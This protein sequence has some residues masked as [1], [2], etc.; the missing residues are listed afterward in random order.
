MS[1]LLKG[2]SQADA[3]P[4]AGFEPS[5]HYFND[6]GEEEP[7]HWKVTG[8]GYQNKDGV[9]EPDDANSDANADDDLMI[10][11]QESYC[12]GTRTPRKSPLG[13]A[14]KSPGKY[15]SS[16]SNYKIPKKQNQ[17]IANNSTNDNCTKERSTSPVFPEIMSFRRGNGP[18]RKV[19]SAFTPHSRCTQEKRFRG[20]ATGYHMRG[21]R[22][23]PGGVIQSTR[24]LKTSGT[25]LP[26][27][28]LT[29][30]V[31]YCDS[32]EAKRK[33]EEMKRKCTPCPSATSTSSDRKTNGRLWKFAKPPE[34]STARKNHTKQV[35]LVVEIPDDDDE[36]DG[37]D[38]SPVKSDTSKK[39]TDG[40]PN[41]A[42]S[43]EDLSRSEANCPQKSDTT[44]TSENVIKTVKEITGKTEH[45]DISG[46]SEDF[47]KEESEEEMESFAVCVHCGNASLTVGKCDY[48]ACGK[49]I[50][51]DRIRQRKKKKQAV[52]PTLG[53]TPG[54]LTGLTLKTGNFYAKSL[55]DHESS[56]YHDQDEPPTFPVRP[57]RQVKTY[58]GK[59]S[60]LQLNQ[61]SMT[62][63]SQ[64]P[65][66][67][68]RIKR[69]AKLAAEPECVT[70]SS[71]EEEGEES[72]TVNKSQADSDISD[73][74]QDIA[75]TT[76]SNN[77]DS[78]SEQ[79][80][81]SDNFIQ[82][83]EISSSTSSSFVQR[84]KKMRD[85]AGRTPPP[86]D[87]STP[88][89]RRRRSPV[90]SHNNSFSGSKEHLSAI[91]DM[92]GIRIGTLKI[93]MI[94][95]PVVFT[96]DFID[97]SIT[98]DDN[99]MEIRLPTNDIVKVELFEGRPAS[100]VNLFTTP[101]LG[102]VLRE[103]LRM[104]KATGWFDPGSMVEAEKRII[105]IAKVDPMD[106]CAAKM[107]DRIFT[108]VGKVNE[109]SDIM[110][111]LSATKANEILVDNSN[112]NP[113]KDSSPHNFRI[114]QPRRTSVRR[115]T[116]PVVTETV[117]LDEP[118][119]VFTGP[120]VKL[121]SYPPP[122]CTGAITITNEDLF[123]LHE[124]EFLNDVII[125]FYLK[126]LINNVLGQEDKKRTHI[127]SSFF[128]KRLSQRPQRVQQEDSQKTLEHRRHKQVKNWTRHVDLFEKD[129]IVVPINE[130][131]H[132][133][134][135][136]ICFP[137]LAVGSPEQEGSKAK[138]KKELQKEEEDKNGVSENHGNS[139]AAS[140]NNDDEQSRPA[141]KQ[142]DNDDD[143]AVLC[144]K[145]DNN[146]DRH[147]DT[148]DDKSSSGRTDDHDDDDDSKLSDD[149]VTER[150]E[151]DYKLELTSS[152]DEENLPSRDTIQKGELSSKKQ[153]KLQ[154]DADEVTEDNSTKD[155]DETSDKGEETKDGDK[156]SEEPKCAE[157]CNDNSDDSVENIKEE[158]S[159]SVKFKQP[160]ILLFDSL[161]GPIH[162]NV[163]KTLK[164]YLAVEWES[165]KGKEKKFMKE[166][167]RGSSVKVPQQ[168]NYSD[169]GVF[170]LHYVEMFFKK[171]PECF[172][173]PIQT[174]K[175]WFQE[176]EIAKK[177]E[178]IMDLINRLKEE[179]DAAKKAT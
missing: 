169:C 115:V 101:R 47:H 10:V 128:Y 88:V 87:V 107:L 145:A 154:S 20:N 76:T 147:S 168:S 117:E 33:L 75:E 122:P 142:T 161:L 93:E 177:R 99:Q 54:T 108:H 103:R 22:S 123:C 17:S 90:R 50:N 43:R 51:A 158:A 38:D 98:V 1:D 67:I 3:D 9:D 24:N 155:S 62:V 11:E 16:L 114:V 18:K 178:H 61:R 131:A 112:A 81:A 111:K 60:I 28:Y 119:R 86:I 106:Q 113:R 69:K 174:L 40:K 162:N 31:G 34:S 172:S 134:L 91:V 85:E 5:Y 72:S 129:F 71:D 104:K 57:V 89:E 63:T 49:P 41:T 153:E 173:L 8:E 27:K 4:G 92:R 14:H 144:D 139:D 159:G 175:S 164:D 83:S 7:G 151:E 30:N 77:C 68:I 97:M 39:V 152:S 148:P 42:A 73:A 133:F 137:G 74:Q 6:D 59:R 105:F 157:K 100:L 19:R 12:I 150:V 109:I 95:T 176:E 116:K 35:D 13:N 94:M 36:D 2:L 163:V 56:V 37:D 21:N 32:A 167:V 143:S 25:Q 23:P 66:R 166:L 44:S 156:G 138:A 52:E 70:I 121:C 80:D 64:S 127:F 141:G 125:D 165:R 46:Q 55:A 118:T 79:S 126:Y 78:N 179:Q 48:H 160:C 170:L 120:V 135:A 82:N 146:S 53:R 26:K 149:G 110:E 29:V 45:I 84:R 124:E 130:S 171:P 58:P 102:T 65:G 15:D 136:I 96:Q 140:S 132:W